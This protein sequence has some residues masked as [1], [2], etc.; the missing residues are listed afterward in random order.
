MG[1]APN[2]DSAIEGESV[3]QNSTPSDSNKMGLLRRLIPRRK[4]GDHS[5]TAS[6]TNETSEASECPSP[7]ASPNQQLEPTVTTFKLKGHPWDRDGAGFNNSTRLVCALLRL[8]DDLGFRVYS[9]MGCCWV[10]HS[11]APP[12]E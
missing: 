7:V 12:Q 3:A 10:F 11:P 5:P 1:E 4:Q 8:L 6:A 2:T 9:S